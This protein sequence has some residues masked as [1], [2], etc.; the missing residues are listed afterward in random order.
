MSGVV[1]IDLVR[2]VVMAVVVFMIMFMDRMMVSLGMRTMVVSAV[3]IAGQ[4]ANQN[5]GKAPASKG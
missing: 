1:F 4:E 2:C 3:S 5:Q